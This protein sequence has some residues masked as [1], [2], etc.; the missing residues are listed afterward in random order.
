MNANRITVQLR[1]DATDENL[2][3]EE[4][5]C[6]IA[7]LNLALSG[8][9]QHISAKKKRTSVFRIVGL[10]HDS[11]SAIT[12]ESFPK[13]DS[14]EDNSERIIPAFFEAIESLNSGKG[15]ESL[16]RNVLEPIHR[17]AK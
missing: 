16:P 2:T 17:I 8:L 3:L 1:A 6:R 5:H 11:P 12:V 7:D 10:R 14:L 15:Y 9:D 13:E 4:F